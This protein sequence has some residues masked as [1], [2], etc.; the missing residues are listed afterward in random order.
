MGCGIW[1]IYIQWQSIH[2]SYRMALIWIF[3]WT[4]GGDIKYQLSIHKQYHCLEE[5]WTVKMHMC[6]SSH[7]YM[8]VCVCVCVKN[9]GARVWCQLAHKVIL[10]QLAW[11]WYD[12]SHVE[13]QYGYK[14]VI[15]WSGTSWRSMIPMHTSVLILR[16]SLDTRPKMV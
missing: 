6:W 8:C 15:A 5:L 3:P 7:I 14:A 1:I 4:L 10:M 12:F 11:G 13:G 9:G 2:F 16:H